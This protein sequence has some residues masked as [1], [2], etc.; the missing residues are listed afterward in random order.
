MPSGHSQKKLFYFKQFSLS[1]EGCGMKIGTD[2][3]LLG[4]VAA[5]YPARRLLDIGTGC[6]LIALMLAQ[7]FPGQ[8]TAIDIDPNAI[9]LARENVANSPWPEK[10]RVREISFQDF[11]KTTAKKYSLLV[12]NPPYFHDSLH[13]PCKKRSLARH[14]QGLPQQVM[15]EGVRQVIEPEGIFVLILPFEQEKDFI[16]KAKGVSLFLKRRIRVKPTPEKIPSRV[17]MVFGLK[18][19]ET[20]IEEELVIEAGGRHQYSAKYKAL[21]RDYYPAF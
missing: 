12:C 17:I 20:V 7:K 5:Q 16:Q 15:L 14:S 1:D 10:V 4:S 21:T 8:I 11:V 6:G 9:S 18:P 13:S 19:A 2:G 3:V